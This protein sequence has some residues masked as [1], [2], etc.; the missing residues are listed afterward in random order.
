MVCRHKKNERKNEEKGRQ[1]CRVGGEG[2]R[3]HCPLTFTKENNPHPFLSLS[4]SLSLS[5]ARTCAHAP[6]SSHMPLEIGFRT[7]GAPGAPSRS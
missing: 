3:A 4:L 7:T 1:G 5:H 2:A 6:P